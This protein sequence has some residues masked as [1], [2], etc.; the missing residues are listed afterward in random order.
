MLGL[1]LRIILARVR[2]RGL[3][4]KVLRF[5]AREFLRCST[6]RKLTNFAL[7]K[8]QKWLR[9]DRL[10]SMPY[11]Y[12]IDPLNVCNLRCPLCP[13]G[14]GELM[15]PQGKMNLE[16]FKRLVDQ[17]APYAYSVQLFNWGE[18][19]LHPHIFDMIRYASQ[20]RISVQLSSNLNYFSEEMAEQ[21]VASGLARL[22][23]PVDGATEETY[24]KYRRGGRLEI[25][26]RNLRLLVEAKRR[27]GSSTPFITLLT[28]VNRYNEHE[29]GQLRQ[30]AADLGLDSFS[31]C[32]IFVNTRDREQVEEWL[33]EDE[34]L[35]YY[36]YSAEQLENVWH[37][38]DL[39][40][41]CTINWDGGVAP[42]CWLQDP[43]H[44]F[45]NA[46]TKPLREIWNSE[47]YISS[48]RVFSFGGPRK[49]PEQTICTRCR[50]RPEYLIC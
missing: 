41:S 5:S 49:G 13:T 34:R 23:V 33:P 9:R 30:M 6:P 42:C 37:C 46:F 10:V 17:I 12:F 39:W 40:E 44:D 8:V 22:L 38:A 26:I 29:L 14:R 1:R 28:L 31:T 43:S 35:S 19:F 32:P 36:D 15:R 16:D 45:D 7:A 50:G 47:A 21:A 2:T 25:V 3:P 27:A 24:Q 48:R 20:R 18:P 11:R 4:G